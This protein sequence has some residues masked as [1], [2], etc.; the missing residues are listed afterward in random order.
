[1]F[2]D[3]L[4]SLSSLSWH[5]LRGLLRMFSGMS[6]L[7]ISENFGLSV[8]IAWGFHLK[9][10]CSALVCKFVGVEA[11]GDCKGGDTGVRRNAK[12]QETTKAELE[13]RAKACCCKAEVFVKE[14]ISPAATC[15]GA[16]SPF[17]GFPPHLYLPEK[18]IYKC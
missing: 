6:F 7:G 14:I 16:S 9:Y 18:G 12:N 5:N 8:V 4:R 11:F 2:L 13:N 10:A 15:V 3:H 1:M 17:S